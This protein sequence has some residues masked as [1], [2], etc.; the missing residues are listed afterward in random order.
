MDS[1]KLRFNGVDVH[2]RNAKGDGWISRKVKSCSAT[3]VSESGDR[4]AGDIIIVKP[5]HDRAVSI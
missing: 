5:G 4:P 1:L 3:R 2:C